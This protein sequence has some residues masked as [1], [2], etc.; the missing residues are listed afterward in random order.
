MHPVWWEDIIPTLMQAAPKLFARLA[1]LLSNGLLALE[2]QATV[3]LPIV[4]GTVVNA[5]YSTTEHMSAALGP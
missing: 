2:A 4:I 3:W 1:P 5:L